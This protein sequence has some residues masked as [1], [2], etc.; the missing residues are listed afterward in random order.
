MIMLVLC[1]CRCLSLCMLALPR[2]MESVVMAHRCQKRW[3]AMDMARSTAAVGG[4]RQLR[5]AVRGAPWKALLRPA[6][7][8]LIPLFY[9]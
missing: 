6:L 3:A 4:W 7:L 5:R 9:C 1:H 8:V 2:G